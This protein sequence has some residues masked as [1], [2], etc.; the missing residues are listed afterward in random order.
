MEKTQKDHTAQLSSLFSGHQIT[1]LIGAGASHELPYV[2][3]DEGLAYPLGKDLARRIATRFDSDLRQSRITLDGENSSLD[4]V[5][6]KLR[7]AAGSTSDAQLKMVEKIQLYVKELFD[8]INERRR[9]QRIRG[10]YDLFAEILGATDFKGAV[11]V[12]TNYDTELEDAL[13]RR[14][15]SYRTYVLAGESYVKPIGDDIRIYKLHGDVKEPKTILLQDREFDKSRQA[16][17]TDIRSALQN[18]VLVLLGHSGKDHDFNKLYSNAR[19]ATSRKDPAYVTCLPGEQ[20]LFDRSEGEIVELVAESYPCSS[21][22]GKVAESLTGKTV[23]ELLE[24]NMGIPLKTDGDL[25]KQLDEISQGQVVMLR[26]RDFSG[27][28]MI[29]RRVLANLREEERKKID[30]LA[31]KELRTDEE[32]GYAKQLLTT[33]RGQKTTVVEATPATYDYVLNYGVMKKASKADVIK[34]VGALIKER[35]KHASAT[36]METEKLTTL[37]HELTEQDVS[38]LYKHFSKTPDMK[39]LSDRDK[40]LIALAS[41][42]NRVIIP[43]LDNVIR[44]HHNDY[45]EKINRQLKLENEALTGLSAFFGADLFD[46]GLGKK[47]ADAAPEI[48]D[49][50]ASGVG[51]AGGFVSPLAAF[52]AIG[53]VLLGV[54]VLVGFWKVRRSEGF[55]RIFRAYSEW[56]LLPDQKRQVL[57]AKLDHVY[58]QPQGTAHSF[59]SSWFSK[60]NL[61]GE[62]LQTLLPEDKFTEVTQELQKLT[63]SNEKLAIQMDF[64]SRQL[65]Q[66]EDRIKNLE[67]WRRRRRE[68]SR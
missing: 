42:D 64:F 45:L 49:T 17:Y 25:R 24:V 11:I 61:R 66:H 7:Q 21:I 44:D 1:V 16:F 43:L 54:S 48:V 51:A 65:A 4:D 30:R 10:P 52:P 15:L 63:E 46:S 12:T 38:D 20:P 56:V 50:V 8:Q 58:N 9:A 3:E 67:G 28:T 59:F 14:K 32:N 68:D 39:E 18:K 19:K 33:G 36:S 53:F 55:E 5:V 60:G 35:L 26:G 6:N 2:T 62:N 23:E 34:Q 47:F 57:C 40:A 13:S 29:V 31:L 27:K 37:D 41:V 22:L